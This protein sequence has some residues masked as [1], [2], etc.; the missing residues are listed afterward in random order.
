MG[1]P[2]NNGAKT[3]ATQPTTFD[4][5]I[6]IEGFERNITATFWYNQ[7][8]MEVNEFDKIVL[9]DTDQDLSF[10][11]DD[12]DLLGVLAERIEQEGEEDRKQAANDAIEGNL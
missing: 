9:T 4:T 10:L 6:E 1:I 5:T 2:N 7:V 12:S 3:M 8:T 11:L